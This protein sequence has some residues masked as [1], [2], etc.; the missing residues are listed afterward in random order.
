MRSSSWCLITSPWVLFLVCLA[1]RSAGM[2]KPNLWLLCVTITRA[3]CNYSIFSC[4]PGPL[5]LNL[6]TGELSPGRER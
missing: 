3:G 5:V 6:A 1:H 4:P 2:R